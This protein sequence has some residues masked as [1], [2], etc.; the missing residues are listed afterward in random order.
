MLGS[1]LHYNEQIEKSVEFILIEMYFY[2]IFNDGVSHSLQLLSVF[3][4]FTILFHTF[5]IIVN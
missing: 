3:D 1:Y 2:C 4:L 5:V